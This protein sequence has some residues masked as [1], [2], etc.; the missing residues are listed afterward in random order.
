VILLNSVTDRSARLALTEIPGCHV[1][2]AQFG[3]D[4]VLWDL[5]Q[6]HR[7]I[8]DG[9]YV[10]VGAHHPTEHSN[11]YLLR[12]LKRWR[13]VNIDANRAAITQFEAQCSDC[14]NVAA[15]ISD[16]EEEVTF[17]SFS[18]SGINTADAA[19]AEKQAKQ[20]TLLSRQRM[21]TRTLTSVLDGLG[22]LP[23]IALLS[24]DVEGYDLRVLQSLDWTRY[25]P[26]A[27]CI[28]SIEMDLAKPGDNEIFRFLTVLGY[29]LI[30][31]V[32]I[33][34]LYFCPGES[35]WQP[36]PRN[37]RVLAPKP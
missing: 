2:F 3:E 4:C 19:M 1:H 12:A 6:L 27:V 30:S 34:S 31:H 10:D 23:P 25:R 7:R 21:R 9:F 8:E 17:S 37:T 28:E 24:V 32:W 20:H 13:G 36:R 33:T 16:V 35:A 14:H 26:F 15:V 29:R 5:L 22:P 11:T 18:Q